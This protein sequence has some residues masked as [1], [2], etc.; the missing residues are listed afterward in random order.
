MIVWQVVSQVSLCCCFGKLDDGARED[1]YSMFDSLLSQ[2][3]KKHEYEIHL[4]I[5]LDLFVLMLKE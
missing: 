1:C 5:T 4:P 2:A 3:K